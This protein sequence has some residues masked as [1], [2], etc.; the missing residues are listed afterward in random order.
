MKLNALEYKRVVSVFPVQITLQLS[1]SKLHSGPSFITEHVILIYFTKRPR[2][3][4]MELRAN[5]VQRFAWLGSII[6]FTYQIVILYNVNDTFLIGYVTRAN[7]TRLF[8]FANIQFV[9]S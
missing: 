8:Y 3:Y 1:P 7:F 6:R 5:R 4:D 2:E 9:Y